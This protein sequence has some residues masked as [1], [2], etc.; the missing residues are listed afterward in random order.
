MFA[1]CMPALATL[2]LS[3][4]NSCWY[5]GYAITVTGEAP[6]RWCNLPCPSGCRA[7]PLAGRWAEL[8]PAP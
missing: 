2:L 6:L 3:L 1:A 8:A 7:H 5:L 4:I